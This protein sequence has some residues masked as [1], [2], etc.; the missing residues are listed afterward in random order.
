MSKIDSQ[1]IAEAWLAMHLSKENSPVYLENFWGY[2]ALSDLCD[3]SPD[4]CIE[5]IGRIL[6]L[7]DEDFIVSNLAAGPLE[8]LLVKHGDDVVEKIVSLAKSHSIWKKLLGG[9]WQNDI[10]DQVWL[11]IKS[12]AVKSW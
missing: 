6:A 8:D 1:K 10:N 2:E 9:V 5:V 4:V 3:Q 12:V 11:K 7:N